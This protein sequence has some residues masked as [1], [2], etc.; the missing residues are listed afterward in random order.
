MTKIKIVLI[1]LMIRVKAK[2]S[3]NTPQKAKSLKRPIFGKNVAAYKTKNKLNR[4]AFVFL[5]YTPPYLH[6]KKF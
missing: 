6:V 3:G 5:T 1:T 2:G 4:I